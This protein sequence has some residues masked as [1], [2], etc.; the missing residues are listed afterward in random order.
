M[1]R[2]VRPIDDRLMID[3]SI[4]E[5]SRDP[6]AAFVDQDMI[7]AETL[8]VAG[9]AA[10]VLSRRCPG[11]DTANEDAAAVIGFGQTQGVLVVADGLGGCPGG[12]QAAERAIAAIIASLANGDA[13]DASLRGRILDGF[14]AANRAVLELGIGA[15]STLIAVEIDGDTVR[16]YHV[17]D[18][19]AL[20]V[21]QRGR[22][23]FETLPHAPVAY[24]VE[25]GMLDPK[26]AMHHEDRHVVSNVVGMAEMRIDI[27]PPIRMN[28]RDTLLVATDGLFDNLVRDEIIE[29]VRA[30]A[31]E[32]AVDAL[33][34]RSQKR[35]QS[36]STD[37]PCKPDDL[38]I[39]AFRLEPNRD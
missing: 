11:H 29:A 13:A 4:T 1:L 21:G 8:A 25:S 14:D 31:L 17:G 16:S 38:T 19:C 20:L 37:K 39:V 34:D 10:A 18:S 28:P 36:E 6:R 15:A 7:H 33:G 3:D 9:G 23:H 12:A 27:G 5:P 24:A 2:L 30:G 32:E 22:V 26:D 35:M